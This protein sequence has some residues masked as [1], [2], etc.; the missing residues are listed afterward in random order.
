VTPEKRQR[1][2][3]INFELITQLAQEVLL[4]DGSHAP[5]LIVDGSTN[6]VAIQIDQLAPTFEGRAHQMFVAG[7]SLA[8]TGS[9]GRLQG[10]YFISEAWLSQGQGGKPPHMRPSKD[11]KRIEVL[12]VSGLEIN[13]R[14]VRLAI[15]EMR[16]DGDGAL[17]EIKPW[18]FPDDPDDAADTPL[19]EAFLAGFMGTT[20]LG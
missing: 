3:P 10:V 12:M 6:P 9:A 13:P 7:Q 5:T 11:P 14:Q 2:Q 15:Y 16:R 1:P 17:R 4:R 19:L 8:H 20:G 18:E